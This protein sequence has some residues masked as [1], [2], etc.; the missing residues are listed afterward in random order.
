MVAT[1]K[2]KAEVGPW[3]S[4]GSPHSLA[5]S[6]GKSPTPVVTSDPALRHSVPDNDLDQ[7]LLLTLVLPP[8]PPSPPTYLGRNSLRRT[9]TGWVGVGG[10]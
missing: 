6:L 5:C 2:E 3:E 7:F 9:G 10:L 8:P 4:C 1:V